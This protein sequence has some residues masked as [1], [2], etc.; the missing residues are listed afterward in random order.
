MLR[1]L[2]RSMAMGIQAENRFKRSLI[3]NTKLDHHL[4]YSSVLALYSIVQFK[5]KSSSKDLSHHWGYSKELVAKT[6]NSVSVCSTF[7]KTKEETLWGGGGG[8]VCVDRY[9]RFFKDTE[10]GLSI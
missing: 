10:Q 9:K 7:I 6:P 1:A 8:G 3:K 2:I 5:K 4:L